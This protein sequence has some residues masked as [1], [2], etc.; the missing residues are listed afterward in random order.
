M[1]HKTI[2]E[3]TA[4]VMECRASG[5]SDHQWCKANNISSSSFYRWVQK[6]RAL[7]CD[8]PE[9]G[10]TNCLV[11]SNQEVVKLEVVKQDVAKMEY[12][13]PVCAQ[14]HFIET[15]PTIEITITNATMR[16]SN[17]VNPELFKTA[18][19]YLGGGSSC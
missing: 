5:L 8:V 1:K 16:F 17:D 3:I 4:I 18:L 2:D 12:N 14:S 15:A 11:P 19:L 6:L 7:R 10:T 13:T 9:S